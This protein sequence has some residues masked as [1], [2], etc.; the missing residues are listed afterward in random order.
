MKKRI[1]ITFGFLLIALTALTFLTNRTSGNGKKEKEVAEMKDTG[2]SEIPAVQLTNASGPVLRINDTLTDIAN[3]IAGKKEFKT[4]V[5]QDL[6]KDSAWIKYAGKTN[7]NWLRLDTNRHESVTNWVNKQLAEV[8]KEN[9]N[10]F[11]PFSGPDFLNADLFF[12]GADTVT[13][14]GLEPVGSLPPVKEEWFKD[15]LH[16]Y[17]SGIKVSLNDILNLSFFKTKDMFS[18][19]RAKELNGTTHLLLWFAAR[20]GYSV[21]HVKHI[22]LGHDGKIV[23]KTKADTAYAKS[24][25]RG[26]EIAVVKNNRS[27]IVR[28]FSADISNHG[29]KKNKRLGVF[30]NEYN[31]TNTMVKS[32]SYLMHAANFTS[33]RNLILNRTTH[34]LQDDTG[35][36]YRCIDDSNEWDL[37]LFGTYEKPINLFHM[38]YQDD[39]R[40]AYDSLEIKPLT[41]GIGYKYRKNESTWML[42]S[43]ADKK[44][45][46]N[47]K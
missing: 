21:S 25:I 28:Y 33:V 42:V 18:D 30:L 40:K 7:Q 3:F 29:F 4:Q 1:F 31:F 35:I 36:P 17:L 2:R 32:A 44:L 22:A 13:M 16:R 24:P 45:T 38:N 19:L 26:I 37:T 47:N 11:Y 14:F 23:W 6:V 34:L 8:S 20:R 27:K 43:K 5:V 46:A 10:L 12:P 39:L 9:Y 41:F 15:S